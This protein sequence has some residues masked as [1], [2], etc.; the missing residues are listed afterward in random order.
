MFSLVEVVARIQ[1]MAD[2]ERPVFPWA[3]SLHA[4]TST[5]QGDTPCNPLGPFA[6]FD[7]PGVLGKAFLQ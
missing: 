7:P 3:A 1:S 6:S 4:N 5:A 2:L